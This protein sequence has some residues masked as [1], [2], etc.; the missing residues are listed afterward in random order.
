M[1]KLEFGVDVVIDDETYRVKAGVI[2][3]LGDNLEQHPLAGNGGTFLWGRGRD[4]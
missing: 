3:H 2:A 1:Q 4:G